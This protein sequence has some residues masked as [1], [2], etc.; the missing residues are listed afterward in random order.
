M[1]KVLPKVKKIINMSIKQ[2]K[3]YGDSEVRIEHII[4]SLINDYNNNAIRALL[5]MGVDVDKLHKNIEKKLHKDKDDFNTMVVEKKE[6]PLDNITEN[7]LKGAEKEC[8]IMKSDYLDT[9]HILLATLKVKNDISSLLKGMKINY[10][11]YKISV[12]NSIEPANGD[13]EDNFNKIPKPKPNSGKSNDTPI[14]NNFSVDVTKRATEGKIDPVIGRDEVIQRVAQILAR[15]KK[16]N[17]VLIGDPG[18]GKT[19]IIEGLA[20][21]I[22]Q[23]D[24]PRTLLD[25]RVI[26][27]D[28]TSLV[29]GTKYRGQFEE[30]IK[31][32]VD[33]L[34][35]VDNVI[36]F[37]DE[38]HTM[39]GAGNASGSM[40]AANVLKPALARGDI[41]LIGAT[42]LD[43]Y[44]EHIEKDGAL[45]RRFQQV[46]ISP[47]T[48]EETIKILDKI[49]P[50][51]ESYHK[52]TYPLETIE[53]CVRMADRYI[54]DREFPDKAIDIMDEIG[55]KSQ[56]SIKPPASISKLEEQ[57]NEIKNKKSEVVKKQKYEE[58]AKLRDEEREV[59]EKLVYE[60]E[61]WLNNLNNERTV[62][63]IEDV[64]EV[65]SSMT[66]IPLKRISGDQGKRMLEIED[67]L[68]KSI[69]GQEIALEKIAKSIRR[70]RVGIR[71]P[72]K[73]I[74]T[75]MFL[76][77]TGVGK[78]HI[79]KKLAEYLFGDEDSLIRLDMSEFQE[80]HSISRL[81]G[82]PPG[83]IGHGEG[84]QLTEKV[85][86]KPYS[87][88][89][90]DEIEK[91]NK[92]IYNTLLQLLDDG[93]LTDSSGRK[94]N[95]KN[96]MVIMTSNVGVKKLQDFGTGVGFG[97][98]S[99]IEREDSIKENLLTDEL[100]KQFPPEFLNRLDDV[101]IF[102]SLTKEEISKIIDLELQK[103]KNRVS[104]IGYTLNI[105]K[106][107]RDHLIDV[108]Y[109]EDYGARHLNRSIQKHIEDPVSEEI[110]RGNVKEG[111]VI[112]LTYSKTKDEISIKSE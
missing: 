23:G 21:K 92:E 47:P 76:G 30:R 57:I 29:A 24:A 37:I 97:T 22:A 5:N 26:S 81:I 79:A 83:Y 8:D 68:K 87:I 89:L 13:E 65:V 45:A 43:E 14:L 17:P 101:I 39:V 31:G 74:G 109:S 34:M 70:N 3:F 55:S 98:K 51:Y 54:T 93:Q 60:K 85:R 69:V 52:V 71:N 112:K 64:N 33:E 108:G 105:H 50:S 91:A 88:V 53:H 107:V 84:G 56:L 75:F 73:P 77:P 1:K 19:T 86:R 46:V 100:K 44:R 7:I 102:K 6:Y 2:A 48:I 96:C 111:G 103:L 41:Q 110:L 95:F 59:N 25:K 66:G 32:V 4:I 94:V 63:T 9:E 11:N 18:V 16:N 104:E 72:K 27:L 49:K 10:K 38:L 42:T 35:E 82:S 90:F 15:K 40:D 58:A 28:L 12:E 20:L 99:K 106:T 80:K 67:E 78:T 36:L 62:V 61:K